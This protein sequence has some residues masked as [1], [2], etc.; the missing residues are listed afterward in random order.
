MMFFGPN[1]AGIRAILFDFDGKRDK[2][3]I[4]ASNYLVITDL[5]ELEKIL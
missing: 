1:N 2:K 5:K 3:D 4:F